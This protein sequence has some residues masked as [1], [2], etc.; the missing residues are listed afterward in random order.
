[1]HNSRKALNYD[2]DDNLLKKYYPKTK[3]YKNAWKKVKKFLYK[4]G[5]E[6]RQYSGVVSKYPIS[7]AKTNEIILK[8]SYTYKWL[9]PCVK[10][11]D[12]TNV[13]YTYGLKHLFEK[14]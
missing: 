12:V 2:L 8:L 13:G 1:M 9:G 10:E 3:T 5:F 7:N 6:N 14:N 4:Y 11:F